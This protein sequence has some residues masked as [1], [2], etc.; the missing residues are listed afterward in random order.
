MSEK[1]LFKSIVFLSSL[2][3]CVYLFTLA[4]Q[5]H[6]DGSPSEASV[7]R[8]FFTNKKILSF[9]AFLFESVFVVYGVWSLL[10]N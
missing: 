9:G 2:C 6:A 7:A 10:V 5:Y 8:Q 4:N 1:F 3:L